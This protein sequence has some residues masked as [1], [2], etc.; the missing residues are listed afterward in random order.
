MSLQH[1]Y[2]PTHLHN[3]TTHLFIRSPTYQHTQPLTHTHNQHHTAIDS[4]RNTH[5]HTHTHTCTHAHRTTHGYSSQHPNTQSPIHPHFR[6]GTGDSSLRQSR[7]TMEVRLFAGQEGLPESKRTGKR[8]QNELQKGR[9]LT[10][11]LPT[12]AP[13]SSILLGGDLLLV[14]CVGVF[15]NFNQNQ[16]FVIHRFLID[17]A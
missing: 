3:H 4:E 5:T 12:P 11:T 8:C 15:L 6:R 1:S 14:F 10:S 9:R 7:D 17:S 13:A 16:R 2:S